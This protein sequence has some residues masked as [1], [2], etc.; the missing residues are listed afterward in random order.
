L[1][2]LATMTEIVE[3]AEVVT[4]EVKEEEVTTTVKYKK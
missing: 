1:E 3:E 2:I 4:A